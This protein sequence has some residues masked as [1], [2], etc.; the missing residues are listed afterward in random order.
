MAKHLSGKTSRLISDFLTIGAL[1]TL[2]PH[3]MEKRIVARH[4]LIKID[5][6]LRIAPQYKNELRARLGRPA[7]LPLERMISRLR[8]DY[9][10]SNLKVGRDAMSAHTLHLDLQR[11]VDTWTFLSKTVFDILADDLRE[12]DLELSRI[13][14]NYSSARI[15]ALDA[16]LPKLWSDDSLLGNPS[17]I[18][19]AV[20]YGSFATAGIVA[21]MAGGARVQD[22][23]IRVGGLVTFI[24]QIDRLRVPFTMGS[25]CERL[26]MEMIVIDFFALWDSLFNSSLRN[27][28]GDQDPSLLDQWRA[29]GWAGVSQLEALQQTPHPDLDLWRTQVRNLTAAHVDPDADIWLADVRHWPMTVR[30]TISEA[31]RVINAVVS[32]AR[33]DIRGGPLFIKPQRMGGDEVIGLSAQ[34]GL[35]WAD[36]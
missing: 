14:A 23:T 29:D 1:T 35:H 21:P 28:Y 33:A 13:D 32:A 17:H 18:R 36:G 10:G 20:I 15:W 24:H 25:D 30:T 4:G 3:E 8:K 5:A 27:E 31:Y 11:I 12:I 6:L 16:D 22:A 7:V 34:D 9:E 2:I 19:F 26:F